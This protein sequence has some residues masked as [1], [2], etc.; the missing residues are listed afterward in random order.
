MDKIKSAYEMA[1]E[2][3]SQRE[4]VPRE[5]IDRLEY[6]EAGKMIAAAYLRENGYDLAAAIK[7]QPEERHKYLLEG[8]RE[9][10]LSNIQLP[11]D[12]QYIEQNQ[13][14]MSGLRAVTAT[15]EAL[16]AIFE[17]FKH[18]FNYYEQSAAQAYGQ[19]KDMYRAKI[20]DAANKSGNNQLTEQAI[21]PERYAGF[22]DE[23]A[24]ARL[25]LNDQYQ[26]ILN[27]Q[28]GKLRE[29]LRATS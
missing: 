24:K 13:R 12:Q 19:L 5:E 4:A 17:Q 11:T 18:L 22:R 8:V 21:E 9:T 14:A 28:K 6:L 25:R 27:E 3:F 7:E 20:M 15:Q 10:L 26:N 16:E 23:W 29:I 1:M 2:R